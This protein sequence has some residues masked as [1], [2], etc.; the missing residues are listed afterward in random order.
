MIAEFIE[1]VKKWGSVYKTDLILGLAVVLISLA[2]F[3]LGRLSV[4]WAPHAPIKIE[5]PSDAIDA[6]AQVTGDTKND[7]AV[8][9]AVTPVGAYVAS[10]NG[11]AYYLESCAGANRIKLENKIGFTTEAEARA[12]GYRP[13]ANCSG[14][15]GN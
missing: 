14:L 9:Q 11:S 6:G 5:M 7:A 1:R 8:S 12:A 4:V 10:K 15:S 3:G 13:A 2:S